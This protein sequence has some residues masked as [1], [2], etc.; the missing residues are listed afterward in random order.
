LIRGH[1]PLAHHAQMTQ[2]FAPLAS[3]QTQSFL[4]IQ[5]LDALVIGLP[6]LAAQHQQKHRT[7]PAAAFLGQLTQPL[8]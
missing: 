3:L 5:P 8:T 7:A 4:A 1:R 2:P 6:A